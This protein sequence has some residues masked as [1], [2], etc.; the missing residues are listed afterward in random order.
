MDL[1]EKLI[2]HLKSSGLVQKS[3]RLLLAVSGGLDSVAMSHLF[4][5]I[6]EAFNLKLGVIHVNHGIRAKA[7]DNDLKFVR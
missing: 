3:D 6:K 5:E 7:Y 2:T 4:F 1:Q